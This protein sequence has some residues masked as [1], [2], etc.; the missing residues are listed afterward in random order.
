MVKRGWM[1]KLI[2]RIFF[3]LTPGFSMDLGPFQIHW[4]RVENQFPQEHRAKGKLQTKAAGKR[5]ECLKIL[6]KRTAIF[7]S[8]SFHVILGHGR[9]NNIN[10]P[11]D[12]Q[13]ASALIVASQSY[14]SGDSAEK[15]Y[16]ALN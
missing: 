13:K 3:S 9:I 5:A 10:F 12:T 6:I 11:M 14:S 15:S 8:S 4:N 2:F 7:I 16:L 1:K